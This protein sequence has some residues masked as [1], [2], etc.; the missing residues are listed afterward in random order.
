MSVL[1]QRL[2]AFLDDEGG[3]GGAGQRF[4]ARIRA[5]D[6]VV[7]G[8][9]TPDDLAMWCAL[10]QQASPSTCPACGTRAPRPPGSS[11]SHRRAHRHARRIA[12]G[13]RRITALLQKLYPQ[14]A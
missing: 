8:R 7:R 1:C 9:G 13:D 12:D 5:I 11:R 2:S 4:V 3:N 10:L 6:R 14:D